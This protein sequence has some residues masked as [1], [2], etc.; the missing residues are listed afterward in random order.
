LAEWDTTECA[1]EVR[2]RA[3]EEV[4]AICSS[5]ST[6]LVLFSHRVGRFCA[7]REIPLTAR[8]SATSSLAIWALGLAELCPLDYGLDGRMFVHDGRDDLPDLDLEVSSLHEA[9]VSAF[10]Q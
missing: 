1:A 2:A 5:G 3:A 10:V 6:D 7:Q 8:G 9:A 4:R